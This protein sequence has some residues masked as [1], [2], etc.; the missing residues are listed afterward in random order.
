M[1]IS[2]RP[3]LE[4]TGEFKVEEQVAEPPTVHFSVNLDLRRKADYEGKFYI[5]DLRYRVYLESASDY[6]ARPDTRH[7]DLG[8]HQMSE[9]IEEGDTAGI[10]FRAP[11]Y[12][13]VIEEM[14]RIS[15]QNRYVT[16][17]FE[18]M[19][20][21]IYW[22]DT[23]S[24]GR[25]EAF[26]GFNLLDS[27]TVRKRVHSAEI[28]GI[29][30]PREDVTSILTEL[31]DFSYEWLTI[32]IP[33]TDT[34]G[35]S[36][37]LHD[38]VERAISNLGNARES[39]HTPSYGQ[40]MIDLRNIRGELAVREERGDGERR[41]YLIQDLEDALESRIGER[42]TRAVRNMLRAG[43]NFASKYVHEDRNKLKEEPPWDE[44]K[45]VYA[46]YSHLVWFVAQKL[47]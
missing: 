31:E 9:L 5:P 37:E 6:D 35:I 46:Q 1:A 10:N 44:T 33:A 29:V 39:L 19:D 26:N 32:P 36:D 25:V 42:E 27:A 40:A 14:N 24:K 45:L 2:A 23:S 22:M 4:Y 8:I 12:P 16:F 13:E 43:S 21:F 18:T 47:H 28:N 17:K 38:R 3:E 7:Y 41:W 30:L 11:L 34:D 15:S 20:A